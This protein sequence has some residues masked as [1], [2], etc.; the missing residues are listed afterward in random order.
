MTYIVM[1]VN[2]N[3]EHFPYYE[4]AD[5][6][7]DAVGKVRLYIDDYTEI[8]SVYKEVKTWR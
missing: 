8:D 6:A 7:N 3:G 2:E 4:Q 1:T 5:S